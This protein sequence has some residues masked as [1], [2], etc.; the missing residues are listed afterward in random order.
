[1]IMQINKRTKFAKRSLERVIR[2]EAIG[3]EGLVKYN[4]IITY[5][6]PVGS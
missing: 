6:F 1:M 3:T 5:N 4:L 2:G